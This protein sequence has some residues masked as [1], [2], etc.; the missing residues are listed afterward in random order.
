[1]LAFYVF[2]EILFFIVVFNLYV[3]CFSVFMPA[4]E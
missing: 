3:F 1:M 4:G 2:D